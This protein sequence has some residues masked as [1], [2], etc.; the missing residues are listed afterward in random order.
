MINTPTG[1]Y[2]PMLICE[3]PV[4]RYVNAYTL[5]RMIRPD[6]KADTMLDLQT[7]DFRRDWEQIYED[8]VLAEPDIFVEVLSQFRAGEAHAFEDLW[9]KLAY[10]PLNLPS[11]CVPEKRRH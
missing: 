2:S 3:D 9:P 6:L 4:K 1:R 7:F 10:F 5:H 8:V 11:S